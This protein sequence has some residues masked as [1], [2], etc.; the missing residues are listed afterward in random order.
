MAQVAGAD[1]RQPFGATDSL[2]FSERATVRC[3]ALACAL[4]LHV[5]VPAAA[6]AP[7]PP[8][9]ETVGPADAL[10]RWG[11]L[12]VKPRVHLTNVGLDTNVFNAASAPS[13]DVTATVG[14]AVDTVLR[15]GRTVTTA[16]T[17]SEMVY[18]RKTASQRSL[19]LSQEGRVDVLLA[20]LTPFVTASLLNTH[21]RP[22][23]EIDQRVDQTRRAIGGGV[24]VRLGARTSLALEYDQ[25]Q[26][27]FR[28][29]TLSTALDR[30]VTRSGLTVSTD[31][32]P[33]ST[34]VVRGEAQ[35]DRF[36]ASAA[37]DADAVAL[38]GGFRLKPFALISGAAM[39]G[40]RRFTPREA[41]LPDFAGLVA[42]V[43][44]AYV[45]RET[46]QVSLRAARGVEYSVEADQPYYVSTGGSLT[47][48]QLI[49]RG[50]AL[51]RVGR[52]AL[53][54]RSRLL[55]LGPEPATRRDRH[56]L[57]G[58]GAGIRLGPTVRVGVDVT[59]E[60]RHSAVA[61]RDYEG[62]RAGG[63][64]TYGY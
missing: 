64:L 10:F 56:V 41:T 20:R 16:R 36:E 40:Y 38:L 62:L 9:L 26:L 12:A 7:T 18:F 58:V 27:E 52:D 11:P 6:Q 34:L 25:Q 45:F 2:G 24:A 39:V 44:V 29:A 35:R 19:S 61:L 53:D 50:D 47:V 63:T 48:R 8:S 57:Y 54:Y 43:D 3:L 21:R 17:S 32:T 15:V 37:R 46:T 5:S 60:R 51:V 13:R 28:D 14:P 30:R 1:P 42:D 31:L 22:N 55:P 4:A 49:G 33:L 23:V 59:F